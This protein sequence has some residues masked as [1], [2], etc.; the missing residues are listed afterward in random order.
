MTT[1]ILN[2]VQ[3]EKMIEIMEFF[4][5]NVGLKDFA[6][7]IRRYNN[8]VALTMMSDEERDYTVDKKRINEGFYWLNEL[9][10]IIDPNLNME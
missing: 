5:R 10:E 4:D 1:E 2:T 6:K 9:A 7:I 8:E 3:Q